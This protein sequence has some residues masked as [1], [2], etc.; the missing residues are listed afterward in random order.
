MQDRVD[1]PPI[2]RCPGCDPP[3]EAKERTS[4][5]ERLVEVRYVCSG[6]GMVTKR[7]IADQA[8]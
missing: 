1:D 3:M 4:V 6:C 8:R 5:T 7:A 2:V